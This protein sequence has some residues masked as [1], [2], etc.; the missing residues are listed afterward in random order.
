[1]RQIQSFSDLLRDQHLV[2]N[3]IDEAINSYL[4]NIVDESNLIY[5]Q[6]PPL[7]RSL[8]EDLINEGKIVLNNSLERV[9]DGYIMFSINYIQNRAIF[10][11]RRGQNYYIVY[12]GLENNSLC[13]KQTNI[14]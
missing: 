5:L 4:N 10:F 6:P 1:M 7:Q 9:M 12:L 8:N 11:V 14:C 2:R 13:I 3:K